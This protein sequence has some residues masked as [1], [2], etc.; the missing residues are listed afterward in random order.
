MAIATRQDIFN[1]HTKIKTSRLYK[2][3]RTVSRLTG[4]SVQRNKA[5]V[6]ANAFAHEAG[7]HQDGFL[8]QRKTYE[9]M[10]PQDVGIA[11]AELVLGK[12]S[13]R[14]AFRHRLK[15]L[16]IRLN[17]E[18]LD[19]AYI[20]FISLADKKKEIYDD[21]LLMLVTEEGED[22]APVFIM[23]YMHVSTGTDAVPTATVR[24]RKNKLLLQ[25]AACGDGP[26]DAVLNTIDRITEIQGNL[27]DFSLQAFEQ[28][29]K[30]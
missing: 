19:V 10:R 8:K 7:V 24:L 2:I 22:Y 15:E 5:I 1:A 18:E 26:V 11:D 29:L 9:I 27:V 21:D 13:G 3:S 12:H 4:I 25:D 6:G 16:G 17:K 20:K 30:L 23:D 14:H 28:A